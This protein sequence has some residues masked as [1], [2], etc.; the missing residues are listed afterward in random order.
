MQQIFAFR[1]TLVTATDVNSLRW[2]RVV[3]ADWKRLGLRVIL[4]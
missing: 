1:R 4:P 3:V 2:V